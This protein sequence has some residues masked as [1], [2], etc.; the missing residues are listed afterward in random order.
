M[1]FVIL[2]F[3][4]A[5]HHS[6]TF[7]SFPSIFCYSVINWLMPRKAGLWAILH[8][9][10]GWIW[11]R[12]L[13]GSGYL[14]MADEVVGASTEGFWWTT[15][16]NTIFVER[17]LREHEL[18]RWS[19]HYGSA[20]TVLQ[21]IQ[22]AAVELITPASRGARAGPSAE[23]RTGRAVQIT[24]NQRHLWT[25]SASSRI[26]ILQKKKT[27]PITQTHTFLML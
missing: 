9:M 4:P 27:P 26:P 3:C 21:G 11:R 16:A 10:R 2:S 25:A 22:S 19:A 24:L 7:H 23:I 20:G 12:C 1:T 6:I 18:T 17:W 14:Q 8:A 15:C 13:K 5:H